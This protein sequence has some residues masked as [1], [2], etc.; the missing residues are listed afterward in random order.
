MPDYRLGKIYRLSIGKMVYIGST[1]QPQLSMRLGTHKSSYKRW[2]NGC[3]EY[4]TSFELFQLGTPTI[5]L[6][7]S[8]PCNSR[9]ELSARE[10]HH[11]RLNECVNLR[12]AGQTREQYLDA[13]QEKINKRMKQYYDAN[14]AKICEQKKQYRG[15]NQ[16]KMN[17]RD[18]QYY[19]ANK[20]KRSEYYRIRYANNKR[21]E[22]L[23][24]FI[25]NHVNSI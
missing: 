22:L 11:Q 4:I 24:L 15:A 1:T 16:E 2:T 19:V 9:D 3:K 12:I 20:E 18:K 21:I 25:Q 8:Y 23:T 6:I 14:Q 13:N 7:E 17:E 5:E 10:G